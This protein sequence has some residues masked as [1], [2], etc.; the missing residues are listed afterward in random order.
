VTIAPIKSRDGV[1]DAGGYMASKRRLGERRTTCLEA[2]S[3]MYISF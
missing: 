2:A 3:R 1:M